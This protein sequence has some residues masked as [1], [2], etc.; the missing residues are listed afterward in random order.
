MTFLLLLSLLL[1]HPPP[2]SA[3]TSPPLL[4]EESLPTKS[5][6][7]PIIP[8]AK[9][10]IFYTFYEAQQP[11]S[12]L[13][14][15]PLLIWLQGGPGCSSM[16]GNFYELGPWRVSHRQRNVQRVGLERNSGSWNRIFG[17]LFLDNPIG[18]GFSIAETPE[19][20][21][22]DQHGV[23]KHLFAAVT[24]F[25]GLDPS[26]KTRPIYFTGESYAGKYVPAIGYYILKKNAQ[27]PPSKQVNNGWRFLCP[28]CVSPHFNNSYFSH[29]F[30]NLLCPK[31]VRVLRSIFFSREDLHL[32]LGQY[33]L[34]K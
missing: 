27:L 6:Y 2:I 7:L 21:P 34:G 5:G 17:L 25:V 13:S 18:A 19:E 24:S 31:W 1:H 16:L 9:S 10:A 12:S 8:T 15:T 28:K 22:R 26:F 20:I 23:A 32:L 3:A 4:P 29:M 14:K 33:F 11:N 30:F